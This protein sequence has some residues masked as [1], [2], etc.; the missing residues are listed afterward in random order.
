M[1]Q[2]VA[3][4]RIDDADAVSRLV[5][6]VSAIRRRAYS[7]HDALA[8]SCIASASRETT[9]ASPVAHRG[10]CWRALVTNPL[11]I[12]GGRC[13]RRRRR[14]DPSAAP[15][16]R[17]LR[18]ER[19]R[20]VA[21]ATACPSRSRPGGGRCARRE[22]RSRRRASRCV[23]GLVAAR[24]GSSAEQAVEMDRLR[25]RGASRSSA[26]PATAQARRPAGWRDATFGTHR[27][28]WRS[29]GLRWRRSA[30]GRLSFGAPKLLEQ[31]QARDAS[32]TACSSTAPVVDAL[33]IAARHGEID[34]RGGNSPAALRQ[35][36]RGGYPRHARSTGQAPIY[37]G[38][39]SWCRI[40]ASCANWA[41][42]APVEP[43]RHRPAS[44]AIA[45]RT[46]AGRAASSQ[47]QETAAAEERRRRPTSID[48][49]LIW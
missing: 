24:R 23:A 28:W 10:N 17:H 40:V 32:A 43:D 15:L 47:Q 13:R 30:H 42:A 29:A 27:L 41:R 8:G 31:A 16:A 21:R 35:A 3:G 5:E 12:P 19:H 7:A 2:Y 44:S 33:G 34:G 26:R 18:A 39:P 49:E 48:D 25:S 1:L 38:R 22:M 45:A 6:D 20:C 14:R 4:R 46:L 36:W 9:S 37:P 11:G